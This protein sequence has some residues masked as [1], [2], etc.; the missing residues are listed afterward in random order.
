MEEEREERQRTTERG[1]KRREGE[2][3]EKKVR[4]LKIEFPRVTP[5]YVS[6]D[7]CTI[8]LSPLN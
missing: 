6:P 2:K 3:D 4:V 8:V 7:S 5:H 1:E